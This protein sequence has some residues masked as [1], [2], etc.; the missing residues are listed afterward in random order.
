MLRGKEGRKEDSPN[1][2][3]VD[4]C[5]YH[6]T[7]MK[8]AATAVAICISVLVNGFVTFLRDRQQAGPKMLQ[9]IQNNPK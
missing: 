3:E 9:C 5:D 8:G 7:Q 2:V 1:K 6:I 4:G